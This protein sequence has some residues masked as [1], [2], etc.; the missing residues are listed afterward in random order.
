MDVRLD[1][2]VLQEWLS[3]PK[4]PSYNRALDKELAACDAFVVFADPKPSR[5]QEQEVGAAIRR[6]W[7]SDDFRIVPISRPGESLPGA[8]AWH[9]AVQVDPGEDDT[10]WHQEVVEALTAETSPDR[11]VAPTSWS[12]ESQIGYRRQLEKISEIAKDDEV[13]PEDTNSIMSSW[14]T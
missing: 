4:D 3:D 12:E 11:A 10:T 7:E 1:R 2:E 9:Q 13:G 5:W 6:E 14:F 8:L